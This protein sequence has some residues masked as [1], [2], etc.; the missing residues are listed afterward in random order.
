MKHGDPTMTW[1]ARAGFETKYLTMSD[2]T[3]LRV[4]LRGP[5][6]AQRVV[7]VHGF[8]QNASAWRKVV[9]ELGD[10]VRAV[11]VDLR[12]YAGSDFSKSGRYDMDTLASDVIRVL[13]ET[14][15]EGAPGPA[16]LVA[17]DW[18]GPISWEVATRRPD[19]VKH[20]VAMNAPHKAVYARELAQNPKQRKASWYVGVFQLPFVEYALS[21]NGA[22]FFIGALRKSA[23]PGTFTDEDLELSLGPMRDPKR[24][25]AAFAYYREARRDIAK[26]PKKAQDRRQVTVPTTIL[27]GRQDKAILCGCAERIVSEHVPH[28]TIR[29]LDDATHWVPEEEPKAVARAILDAAGA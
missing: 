3:R 29:W 13:E 24:L 9:A 18:G 27:W 21:A 2:G 14:A 12:G 28:A 10:S 23:R 26:N 25:G 7:L 22:G 6:S 1:P 8:P 16:I 17:H 4:L 5:K 11:L 20:L 19:L 15:S